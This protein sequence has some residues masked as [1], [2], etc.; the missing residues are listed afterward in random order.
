[1]A[2]RLLDMPDIEAETNLANAIVDDVDATISAVLDDGKLLPLE[3]YQN[4]DMLIQRGVAQYLTLGT[5]AA[6]KIGSR[7]CGTSSTTP[8]RRRPPSWPRPR[9][10]WSSDARAAESRGSLMPGGPSMAPP[11]M[12][13]E[14]SGTSPTR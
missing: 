13:G 3:P 14:G 7:C 11:P 5:E 12:R 4:L 1:M 2:L 9:A 6:P 8:P 10:R